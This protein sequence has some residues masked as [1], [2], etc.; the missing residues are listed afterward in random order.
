M[1]GTGGLLW[2]LTPVRRGHTGTKEGLCLRGNIRRWSRNSGEGRGLEDKAVAGTGYKQK[3]KA[4]VTCGPTN[5][6]L[7]KENTYLTVN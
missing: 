2:R 4:T 3:Q 7:F 1:H 6:N 5:T